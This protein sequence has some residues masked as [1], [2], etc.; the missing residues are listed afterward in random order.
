MVSLWRIL[1]P[2]VFLLGIIVLP[3]ALRAADKVPIL[4]DTDIGSDIDDAFALALALASPEVDL[5]GVTTVTSAAEDRAWM[6]CRFLT[7]V[8]RRN[9]PVAW[10]RDPQPSSPIEGQI[11]YRRHPAVIFNRTSKPVKETAVEFLY[12]RLKAKP[13]KLTLVAIGPLTNIARLLTDHPDCKPWIKRIVLM[14]G[15]V[16]V[17]YDGKPPAEAEWN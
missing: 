17:G 5:Q 1:C 10:G 7:A 12:T 13:G 15:S 3:A 11:Q 2:G 9:V 14:G 6:V 4:L 16:R 8:G